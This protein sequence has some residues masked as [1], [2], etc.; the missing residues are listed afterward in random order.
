MRCKFR[1]LHTC[2]LL[3]VCIDPECEQ[4]DYGTAFALMFLSNVDENI[5]LQLSVAA[6]DEDSG[7][8]RVVFSAPNDPQNYREEIVITAGS[9]S[10]C[11]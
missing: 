8:V 1:C 3:L 4:A 2:I 11:G 5:D 10:I 7:D 6:P 9:V